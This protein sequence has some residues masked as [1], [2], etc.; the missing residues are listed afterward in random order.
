M[1]R[2]KFMFAGLGAGALLAGAAAWMRPADRGGPYDDYFRALNRELKANGPMCTV[3]LIDL[4][5]L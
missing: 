3:L 4:D 1:N 2:R 5:R